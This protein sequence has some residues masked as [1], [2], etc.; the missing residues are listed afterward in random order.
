MP[1]T[2]SAD[3]GV[4]GRRGNGAGGEHDEELAELAEFGSWARAMPSDAALERHVREN[5]AGRFRHA[6]EPP[7]PARRA[8]IA[9]R[10][11]AELDVAGLGHEAV[12]DAVEGDVV[13]GALAHEQFLDRARRAWVPRSGRSAIVTSGPSFSVRISQ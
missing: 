10:D 12:D 8:L 6:G 9:V 7:V 4:A 11:I 3:H 5:S 2:T 13:V 1:E